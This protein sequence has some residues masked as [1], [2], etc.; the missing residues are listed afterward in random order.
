M[1]YPLYALGRWD[2]ALE[3]PPETDVGDAVFLRSIV[4][5]RTRIWTN[6]GLTAEAKA[7]L[8]ALTPWASKGEVQLRISVE[9]AQAMVARAEGRND[10][11]LAGG[12]ELERERGEGYVNLADEAF[13]E[14]VESA[15]AL[16]D[17]PAARRLLGETDAI[18][19]GERTRFLDAHSARLRGRLAALEGDHETA[20]ARFEEAEAQFRESA[21]PFWLAVALLEHG[22]WLEWR[23]ESEQAAPLLA[24]ARE[25][26]A[27]LD[28]FPWLERL[29]AAHGKIAGLP[30]V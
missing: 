16:D 26:F 12:I 3:E 9:L 5:A 2:A 7:R 30:A 4:V 11:S 27:R 15:L 24:E 10:E 22:E 17:V 19:P 20:G 14:A 23:S 28:A 8:E 25:L 21:V 6:R 18:L 1:T 13:V 29:A